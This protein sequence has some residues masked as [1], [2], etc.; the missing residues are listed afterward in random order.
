MVSAAESA[1]DPSDELP[2]Q[3][4]NVVTRTLIGLKS[5]AKKKLTHRR[6]PVRAYNEI[7]RRWKASTR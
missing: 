7:V 3:R 1:R 5:L 6:D 4:G 2:R